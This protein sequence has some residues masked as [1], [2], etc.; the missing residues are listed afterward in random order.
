M[1]GH[2]ASL[3]TQPATGLIVSPFTVCVMGWP[4]MTYIAGSRGKA[5]AKCW[6][7]YRAHDND[8]TFG[9][10]L[11]M[12]R[13]TKKEPEGRFGEPILVGEEPAFYVSHDG[14]YVQ[15]VRPGSD[16]VINSHPLDVRTTTSPSDTQVGIGAADEPKGTSHD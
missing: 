6:G 3:H 10:F 12:T 16:Q 15:F 14:Q 7:D 13:A 2:S 8:V 4:E 1:S 9:D 11:K 5:L